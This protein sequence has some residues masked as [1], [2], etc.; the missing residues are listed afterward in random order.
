LRRMRIIAAH[1]D[2]N[3]DRAEWK[4]KSRNFSASIDYARAP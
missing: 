1:F 4:V 3:R 2:G